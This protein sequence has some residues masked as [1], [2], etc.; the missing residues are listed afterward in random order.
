[1]TFPFP[2][3][4]HHHQTCALETPNFLHRSQRAPSPLRACPSLTRRLF[5][6]HPQ[7]RSRH[8]QTCKATSTQPRNPTTPSLDRAGE[9]E[10]N[11]AHLRQQPCVGRAADVVEAEL[12]VPEVGKRLSA[13]G[14]SGAFEN[15]RVG[16]VEGGEGLVAE[17]AGDE[18]EGGIRGQTTDDAVVDPTFGGVSWEGGFPARSVLWD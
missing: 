11:G 3:L 15:E 17:L 13:D 7:S 9:R 18:G 12:D 2:A 16:S 1:M 14:F 5:P 4:L 10:S 8:R 6:S